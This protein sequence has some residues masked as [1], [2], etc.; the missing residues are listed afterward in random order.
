MNTTSH[1]TRLGAWGALVALVGYVLLPSFR[2]VAEAIMGSSENGDYPLPSEVPQHEWWG[3]SGAIIFL[4]IAAGV[5]LLSV[6]AVALARERGAGMA[7]MLLGFGFGLGGTLGFVA[8]AA[9]SRAMYSGIAANLTETGADVGAQ[10]AALWAVD[11]GNAGA[12]IFA[13]VLTSAFVVWLAAS[14][15]VGPVAGW[16]TGVLAGVLVVG[17]VGFV[18]LA[19]QFAFVPIFAILAALLFVGSRRAAESA[20]AR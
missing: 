8:C 18:I 4:I 11:I 17:E 2:M 20:H 10:V 1:L 14:G 16:I 3:A 7:R 13:G 12:V 9:G 5:L 6:A 15:V 19:V